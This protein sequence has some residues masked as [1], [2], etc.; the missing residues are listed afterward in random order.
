ML[1]DQSSKLLMLALY[2]C[3]L[4]MIMWLPS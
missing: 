2:D 3:I 4:L 1:T